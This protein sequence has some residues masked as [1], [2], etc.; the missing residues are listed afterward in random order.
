MQENQ[1]HPTKH[2]ALEMLMRINLSQLHFA[3]AANR[4]E[5]DQAEKDFNSAREWFQQHTIPIHQDKNQMW[6][7]GPIPDKQNNGFL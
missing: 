6:Q 2:E 4:G 5:R 3:Q 1:R 7:I